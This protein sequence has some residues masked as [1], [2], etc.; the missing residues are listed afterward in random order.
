[1]TGEACEV[2]RRVRRKYDNGDGT[3][4]SVVVNTA[5]PRVLT[6][7]DGIWCD[8]YK[9]KFDDGSDKYREETLARQK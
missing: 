4:T 7:P 9:E 2:Y 5:A 8:N 3:E 6:G 1:M